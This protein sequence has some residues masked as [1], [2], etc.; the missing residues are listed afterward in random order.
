LCGVDVFDNNTRS[1]YNNTSTY[2]YIIIIIIINIYNTTLVISG[3]TSCR[4]KDSK[5]HD[6]PYTQADEIDL[7]LYTIT[8]HVFCYYNTIGRPASQMRIIITTTVSYFL[9]TINILLLYRGIYTI[10]IHL[11]GRL[12]SFSDQDSSDVEETVF[13]K[14]N[15]RPRFVTFQVKPTISVRDHPR[16]RRSY[17]GKIGPEGPI[18]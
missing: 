1:R 5:R 10:P 3:L 16:S 8:F 4:S 9:S 14:K 18:L 11:G 7:H 15:D 2:T 13:N 17:K 6:I 12:E